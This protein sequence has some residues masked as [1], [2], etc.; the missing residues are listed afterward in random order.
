MNLDSQM[1]IYGKIENMVSEY[2]PIGSTFGGKNSYSTCNKACEKGIYTLKDR[3]SA[4]FPVK[5]DIF[6]RSHIY[7][8]SD[9]NLIGNIEELRTFGINSFRLDFLEENYEEIEYILKSLKEE[10]WKRDFKIIQEV[11]IKEG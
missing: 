9:I 7:N 11:I 2:C 4:K 3:M 10:N 1:L 8:N 5:T 6:C